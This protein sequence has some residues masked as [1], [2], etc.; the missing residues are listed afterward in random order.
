MTILF[1]IRVLITTESRY[2][3]DRKIIRERAIKVLTEHGVKG[4]AEVEIGIVGD[5]KMKELHKKYMND[6]STTDVLSFPLE[7]RGPDGVLRLGMV[8]VSFPQAMKDAIEENILVDEKIA[9]LVSHGILHLLGI[10]HE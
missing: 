3:A 1:M 6:D 10:H 5:R 9:F 7:D 4:K 2:P 8:V